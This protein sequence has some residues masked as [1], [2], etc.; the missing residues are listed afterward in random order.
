MICHI[1]GKSGFNEGDKNTVILLENS[2]EPLIAS[3][4]EDIK[5]H[6]KITGFL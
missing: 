1:C 2:G 4:T 3:A 6:W 5:Y